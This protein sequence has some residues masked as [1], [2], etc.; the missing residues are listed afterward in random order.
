MAKKRTNLTVF[1]QDREFVEV[2]LPFNGA[3][4]RMGPSP[5]PGPPGPPLP[6]SGAT[7]KSRLFNLERGSSSASVTGAS[8]KP[9][10]FACCGQSNCCK[11]VRE[12]YSLKVV[13]L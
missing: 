9:S 6:P 3:P 13:E 8:S 10:I 7:S 2:D 11:K 5:S 1:P 12:S 4:K